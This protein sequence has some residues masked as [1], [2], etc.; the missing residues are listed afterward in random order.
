MTMTSD[1]AP[2]PVRKGVIVAGGSG[3]RLY[4]MT[5]AVN[6]QLL[7]VYDKPMIYY[8]L[9]TLML[10]GIREI[11]IVSSPAALPQFEAVLGDGTQWGLQFHYAAQPAPDGIAHA[12]LMAERFISGAPVTLILGDNIFYRSGL[13]T[14]LAR[15]AKLRHGASIFAYPVSNPEQFGVVLLDEA[16]RPVD[17]QEKPAE[18]PSNLAVTGL[19]FYDARAVD[20]ARTLRPSARGELEI[21]DLNRIYLE[22]GELYVEQLGRGSA[23]LDGGTPDQLFAAAQFVQVLEA[24]TGSKIGCP[25]EVAYRMG[26]VSVA[27]LANLAAGLRPSGYRNL[28]GTTA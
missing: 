23:W 4:P 17:L 21:T 12:L 8:P 14:Q 20:Y 28:C 5:I 6:K 10:A 18:P 1:A 19:Y 15:A 27:E 26:F 22:R 24:R 7:P 16:L 3:T 11:V 2:P 9:T 25:E 13:P